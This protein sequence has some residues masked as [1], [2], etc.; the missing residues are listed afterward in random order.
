MQEQISVYMSIE[1]GWHD[2]II[3]QYLATC[4]SHVSMYLYIQYA[5]F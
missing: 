5:Q 1:K 3:E 4:L 2:V